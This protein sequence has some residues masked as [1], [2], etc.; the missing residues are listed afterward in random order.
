MSDYRRGFGVGI[1]FIDHFN[2]RH[3][4]TFNYGAIANLHT[5]QITRAHTKFF[6]AWSVFTSRFP[7]TASNSGDSTAFALMPFPAGHRLTTELSSNNASART[8]KNTAHL[9]LRA[10]MFR[11]LPS[12]RRCSQTHR[13]G[14]DLQ[15][16]VFIYQSALC[17]VP[18][19]ELGLNQ[20]K[21]WSDDGLLL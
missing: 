20:L 6:Q 19:D 14:M 7:V 15:A 1:L 9:L 4:T 8:N 21:V 11:V 16:T 10:R 2:T 5:L 13:L 18:E 17:Y 12:N 3:V